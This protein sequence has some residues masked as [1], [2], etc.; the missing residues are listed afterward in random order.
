MRLEQGQE[1]FWKRELAVVGLLTRNI[2]THRI[3]PAKGSSGA[4][5][6]HNHLGVHFVSV[7]H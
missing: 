6:F 3:R 4:C 5:R 1:F 2:T 7:F